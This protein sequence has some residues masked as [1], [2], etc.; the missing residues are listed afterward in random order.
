MGFLSNKKW[1][2]SKHFWTCEII[3]DRIYKIGHISAN[4]IIETS[5][6]DHK[7]IY[8]NEQNIL[9]FWRSLSAFWSRDRA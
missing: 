1:G 6:L 2:Q 3:K 8:T 5:V 9:V 4:F 7:I